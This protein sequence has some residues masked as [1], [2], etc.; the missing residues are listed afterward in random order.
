MEETTICSVY[1]FNN[2]LKLTDFKAFQVDGDSHVTR[3]TA[4]KIS[5]KSA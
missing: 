1:K 5:L 4:G 2:E 3:I